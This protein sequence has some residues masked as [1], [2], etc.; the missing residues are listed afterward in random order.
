M[1]TPPQSCREMLL[2]SRAGDSTTAAFA[3][4]CRLAFGLHSLDKVASVGHDVIAVL[5]N[6]LSNG[7]GSQEQDILRVESEMYCHNYRIATRE[8]FLA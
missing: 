8:M 7:E 2:V 5:Q 4:P 3:S 6:I 1:K